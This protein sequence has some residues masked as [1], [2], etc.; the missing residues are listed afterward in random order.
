MTHCPVTTNKTFLYW[1]PFVPMRLVG[2]YYIYVP[3][4]GARLAITWVATQVFLSHY[5]IF[6]IYQGQTKYLHST[7]GRASP[8]KC[9]LSH[10]IKHPMARLL[11]LWEISR[12]FAAP[13]PAITPSGDIMVRVYA[14]GR[15]Q[16]SRVYAYVCSHRVSGVVDNSAQRRGRESLPCQTLMSRLISCRHS[17]RKTREGGGGDMFFWMGCLCFGL[18]PFSLNA[19]TVPIE[20]VWDSKLE[21]LTYFSNVNFLP[22]TATTYQNKWALIP[23]NLLS[24]SFVRHTAVE[25]SRKTSFD[26]YN[27]SATNVEAEDL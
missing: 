9:E 3:V 10:R 5:V 17:T 26:I 23:L 22:M 1:L 8:T 13:Q 20:I 21:R 2:N 15:K 14:K 18:R 24:A 27:P 16:N 19:L 7:A 25:D 6:I 12:C 11:D 4:D